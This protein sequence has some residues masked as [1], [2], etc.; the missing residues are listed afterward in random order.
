M[1]HTALTRRRFIAITAA[2]AGMPLIPPFAGAHASTGEDLYRWRGVALGAQSE[3]LL[4][5][6]DGAQAR[7]LTLSITNEIDRLE[8][9]FSLYR[10]NSAV[11]RLN[12]DGFLENPPAELV[13]LVRQSIEIS[14]QTIGVFDIT[15]Q[16]LWQL[17]SESG[18]RPLSERLLRQ[19]RDLVDYRSVE[20]K[21]DRIRLGKPGMAVTLN[22]IAQGYITDR[23]TDLLK[24]AGLEKSLVHLGE[25]SALG[26][27][28]DGRDWQ[29]GIEAPS[30][31]GTALS[32]QNLSAGQAMATSGSYGTQAGLSGQGHLF[33][34]RNSKILPHWDSL[35]VV[36]GNAATAD[37]FS[38]G[39]SLMDQKSIERVL[40][41]RGDLTVTAIRDGQ[42]V[43][44][45]A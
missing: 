18:G 38:T 12:R 4:G 40:T 20:I 14:D 22:G 2:A 13:A 30:R 28:P 43:P 7:D 42:V 1:A 5:L 11:S 23:V 26:R 32:R 35:T 19:V 25:F 9:I 10:G 16:P 8:N 3:I 15:V 44:L 24:S 17:H 36:A 33:H 6:P 34:P 39:L 21:A 31:P 45:T 37:G 41:A 29:V 27:H